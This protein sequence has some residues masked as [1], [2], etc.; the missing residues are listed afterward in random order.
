MK[1]IVKLGVAQT[2]K[3]IGIMYFVGSIIFCI[4]F[5]LIII[6]IGGK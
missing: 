6:F 4:P 3:V 5:G 1:Q 2:A